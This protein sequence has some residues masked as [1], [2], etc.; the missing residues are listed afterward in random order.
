[1]RDKANASVRLVPHPSSFIPLIKF[2]F[3]SQFVKNGANPLG[4]LFSSVPHKVD[5]RSVSK[6]EIRGNLLPHKGG[7][8]SQ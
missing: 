7:R 4:I 2:P 6:V 1:M 3:R 5:V 8:V